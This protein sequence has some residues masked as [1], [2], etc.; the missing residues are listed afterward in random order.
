VG[1]EMTKRKRFCIWIGEQ[2]RQN[3]EMIR[4]VHRVSLSEAI[5]TLMRAGFI[6]LGLERDI[7]EVIKKK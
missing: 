3:L 4:E 1:V 2:E 6:K 7:Q 5:R